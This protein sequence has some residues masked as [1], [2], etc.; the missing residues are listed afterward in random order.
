M[1]LIS[2]VVVGAVLLA[3][4]Q[5]PATD[6]R[7]EAERLA[8]SGAHAQALKEFQAV[9]AA[10]PDDIEARLWIARL[11]VLL[12]HPRRAADVYESIVAAQP[13]NVD[14]LLGLGEALT[15]AS[16]LREGAD[17]LS[18]A[19]AL[20]ADRPAILT[21]QGRLHMA[22]G[23]TSLALAYFQRAL[24]LDPANAEARLGIESLR[25]E[26]A[27]RID[28]TY[29]FEH[30]ST[31][32]PDT[33]AGAI[34]VNVRAADAVRLFGAFQHARKFTR[35]EDRAGGGVEWFV[36][37]N[38]RLRA[39][40][41]FGGNTQVLPDA[42]ATVDLE[43]TGARFGWLL[44]VRHLNFDTSSTLIWAP[45]LTVSPT[46]RLAVAL[47]YYRSGSDFD[48]FRAVTG[49][50]GYSAKA[51]ARVSR[52]LWISGGYARG[53][54]GLALITSERTTQ[55]GADNLSAGVRFDATPF[56]SI[57]G[58]YEHQWREFDTRVATAMVNLMQ[59][60]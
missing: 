14:A 58:L 51:T 6:Q 16:R 4:A 7:A 20:A 55:F 31:D 28:G 39:G 30:F 9:A 25:A 44:G 35:N 33:H 8:R 13:Q 52:R 48:E 36:R 38:L 27:H 10:N 60:F 26:R 21:A 22:A 49:N 32:A 24:A 2:A 37:R 3:A 40:A 34:E 29:N 42:D 43:Y 46:D 5:T 45:G 47:R 50:D 12:G 18:R 15:S 41:L 23:R 17:A 56:T 54:E 19:E 11:H 57:G 59:R 53:F 1:T